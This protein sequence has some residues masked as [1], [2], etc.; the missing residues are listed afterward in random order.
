MLQVN[1]L[2][3]RLLRDG[4]TLIDHLS[5][6][7]A[8]GDRAALIGEEGD[9]KSTLLKLLY[10]P[11]LTAEYAE[12]DGTFRIDGTAAYLPQ[13]LP[14]ALREKSP[15]ELLK[16]ADP[17][18]LARTAAQLS[19]PPALLRD[20]RP[21]ATL[22][23]GEKVKLQL[24]LLLLKA[25]DVLLL[26]EPSGDLDLPTIAWLQDYL[27]RTRLPVLFASHDGALI[28]TS[29]NML[30]HLEQVRRKT[31]PRATVARMG[32]EEY[33]ERRQLGLERQTRL[34]NKERAEFEQ[35]EARWRRIYQQV[36]AA[37]ESITRADPAGGRLL[38]KKMHSVKS[39]GRR[40]A[41]EEESLTEAADFEESILPRW[42]AAV[43]F[44]EGKTA[45]DFSL[46]ILRA[47]EKLLAEDVRLC[48]R[49]PRKVGIVGKN[50]AGKTTLLRAMAETLLPRRDI[51]AAYM[52]QDY[53]DVL[54][55][56]RTPVDFLAP[57]G[58]KSSRTFARTCLGSMKLTSREMERPAAALSGGTQAKLLFLKMILDKSNLLLLDEPT[59]N[60]SPLSAPV[61]RA[62]LRDFPGA[63]IAVSHDRDFLDEVCEELWEL[64][65]E[66]LFCMRRT[67]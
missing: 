25:P 1:D 37:Q 7:L 55:L 26:D 31:V 15:G 34:A 16:S 67:V 28:R 41:R 47:G 19:L 35:K 22:S 49:G 3:I 58:D 29:A 66:G 52:P 56:D 12:Y 45:V 4:R 30:I 11:T 64:R 9:G 43:A 42:D 59:R 39:Q 18:V 62:M 53:R 2:S 10:D 51:H 6:T 60:F 40:L 24:L 54:P 44:P 8:P 5:F 33:A 27:S 20:M 61:I 13:M 50:G 65:P 36:D 32:Y 17:A 38:K 63:M 23:G 48:V 57:D 21:A 14:S 46:P